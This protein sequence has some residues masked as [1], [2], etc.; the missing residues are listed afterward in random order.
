[1]AD[2]IAQRHKNYTGF[3]Q[4]NIIKAKSQDQPFENN[5]AEY[6]SAMSRRKSKTPENSPPK[7]FKPPR[8]TPHDD[9][10]S[11]DTSKEPRISFENKIIHS[12]VWKQSRC[13]NKKQDLGSTNEGGPFFLDQKWPEQSPEC[14][15][16]EFINNQSFL[17]SL[18]KGFYNF[19]KEGS[20]E[21]KTKTL[22]EIEEGFYSE[23]RK[24]LEHR[25]K[26]KEKFQKE[27]SKPLPM[28]NP[29]VTKDI[30]QNLIANAK[31]ADKLTLEGPDKIVNQST[32]C[33]KNAKEISFNVTNGQKI[34]RGIK[35]P[36]G[37][38]KNPYIKKS[39]TA[40]EPPRKK[41]RAFGVL[42]NEKNNSEEAFGSSQ[43]GDKKKEGPTHRGM[44]KKLKLNRKL[45]KDPK[46][47]NSGKSSGKN[48]ARSR[49]NSEKHHRSNKMIEEI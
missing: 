15:R 31:A 6:F 39:D 18:R 20:A 40:E 2:Y 41:R 32:D 21:K 13:S 14:T 48:S 4:N 26:D 44:Y 3:T 47:K 43:D 24:S 16:I 36:T 33:P 34:Q 37:I 5:F 27:F 8:D 25:R 49:R 29:K 1:M 7:N 11:L 45:P 12:S 30:F 23:A 19:L 35:K 38:K 17:G 9:T 22:E 10:L 28:E 46:N 42:Q